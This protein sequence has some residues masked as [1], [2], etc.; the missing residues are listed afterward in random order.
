VA[1]DARV[2]KGKSKLMWDHAMSMKISQEDYLTL[3]AYAEAHYTTATAVVKKM[4]H[5]L[6]ESE[7]NLAT[8]KK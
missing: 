7:R 8:H 1:G 2:T 6:C 5:D 3:R 4:V